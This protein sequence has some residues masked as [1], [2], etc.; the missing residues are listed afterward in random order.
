MFIP[1]GTDR[2]VGRRPITTCTLIALNLAIFL[3]AAVAVR[4]GLSTDEEIV[5][6]G[7]V[8]RVGFR[9]WTPITSLFL[10]DPTGLL[11]IGFNMLFLWIFGQAVES[12]LGSW[13]FLLFYLA[14]GVAASLAHIVASPAPAI[15]ASGA[16]AA[17]SGAYLVLFPRSTVKVLFLFILIGVV[18]I[19]AP[20]F[21]G[22]Y[23]LLDLLGQV[24]TMF[25]AGGS[26][27][28]AAHLGGTFFG[29]STALVLL[30]TGILKSTDLD[31][32]YLLRQR[33]RRAEMRSAARTFGTAFDHAGPGS[34]VP[35]RV[36]A[37]VA[38][39]PDPDAP[40]RRRIVAAMRDDRTEEAL[41]LYRS[42]PASLALSDADQADLGN[43]ALANS[44]AELAV[45]AYRRLLERRGDV[46][47]GAGGS[48]DDF[49]L[50]VASMLVRRLDRPAEARPF[51]QALVSR[52]LTAQ[53]AALRDALIE[54]IGAGA[55]ST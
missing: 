54:E 17:V 28:Y 32:L 44:D 50:L 38:S 55:E 24:S 15:G 53:S 42:A 11:H 5:R 19:P 43:R 13:W 48:S 14:G 21:I 4:M 20:Y 41:E 6:F 34:Q 36:D 1:L 9:P 49:R 45:R 27:A 37:T 22:L 35:R 10:H 31:L 52:P 51:L 18:H 30:S 39:P 8:H 12:R 7:A 26:T 23:F 46:A 40:L 33:R 29:V 25:G 3:G 47:Q 2:I 16:V